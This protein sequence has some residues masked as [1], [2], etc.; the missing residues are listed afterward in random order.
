MSINKSDESG[1]LVLEDLTKREG[2]HIT[3]VNK[4]DLLDYEHVQ[5]ALVSLAHIHGSAWRWFNINKANRG[6]SRSGGGWRVNTWKDNEIFS[7]Y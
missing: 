4:N 7:E 3:S 6:Q 5:V 1:I 2:K